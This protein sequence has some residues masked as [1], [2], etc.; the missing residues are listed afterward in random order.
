MNPIFIFAKFILLLCSASLVYALNHC[1]YFVKQLCSS[2]SLH[3]IS[4]PLVMQLWC[5]S[6]SIISSKLLWMSVTTC[7]LHLCDYYA[8]LVPFRS[9]LS[10]LSL[11]IWVGFISFDIILDF[12]KKI[13]LLS[14]FFMICHLSKCVNYLLWPYIL[15]QTWLLP[16]SSTDN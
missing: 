12:S 14:T 5:V 8:Q 6:S 9:S 4:L 2:R 13:C 10:L 3:L 7:L 15:P 16:L 1:C 11:L